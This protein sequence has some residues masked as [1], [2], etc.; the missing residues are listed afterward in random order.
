L[1]I[2]IKDVYL[3]ITNNKL[4]MNNDLIKKQ[5][6]SIID[7]AE[8][9]LADTKT[10]SYVWNFIKNQ[11]PSVIKDKDSFTDQMYNVAA[12]RLGLDLIK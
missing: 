12:K 5:L 3:G 4:D 6:L 9:K 11:L 10:E 8:Y 1:W 7:E 2:K